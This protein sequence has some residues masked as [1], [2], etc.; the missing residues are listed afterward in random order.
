MLRTELHCFVGLSQTLF[1]CL[2]TIN[3][4]L[5]TAV[6]SVCLW[7]S[8]STSSKV[9]HGPWPF[10]LLWKRLPRLK[11]WSHCS[12][13]DSTGCRN[14]S[15]CLKL[16]LMRKWPS[17]FIPSVNSFLMILR[18][19]SLVSS[20]LRHSVMFL[21]GTLWG[22]ATFWLTS[23]FRGE[24]LG[25]SVRSIQDILPSSNLSSM[26]HDWL[27]KSK[28]SPAVMPNWR[29]NR[30]CHSRTT[31]RSLLHKEHHNPTVQTKS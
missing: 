7:D 17:W 14:N 1:C 8:T 24:F 30:T 3:F 27:L 15:D 23:C 28:M 20:L 29:L 25:F 4:V 21:Q 26:A 5:P 31:L 2:G 22:V 6:E 18:S 13:S 9:T 19:Q 10:F 11:K 16:K 12:K